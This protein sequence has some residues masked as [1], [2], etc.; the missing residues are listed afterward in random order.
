MLQL[1]P[2]CENCKKMLPPESNE[3]FICSYE[4]TFCKTCVTEILNNVCPNC[5]GG[6][7]KRPIRPLKELVKNPASKAIIYKPIK[8]S[9]NQLKKEVGSIPPRLR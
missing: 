7:Q 4:C 1:K 3:A 2:S 5:S 6:F 9:F 8:E